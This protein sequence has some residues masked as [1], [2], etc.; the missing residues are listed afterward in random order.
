MWS[1]VTTTTVLSPVEHGIE[2]TISTAESPAEPGPITAAVLA[3]LRPRPE[4]Y[5]ASVADILHDLKNQAVAARHAVT[6]P[7][8]T[9]TARL[10]QQLD[11]RRHLD[12][13]HPMI[14]S[15]SPGEGRV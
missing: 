3:A 10:E 11:A 6:Q 2:V 5:Q 15:Y 12:R 9:E 7:T 14:R 13:A 8:E 4:P 1:G